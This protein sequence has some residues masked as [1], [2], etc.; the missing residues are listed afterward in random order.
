[1]K[2]VVYRYYSES[3]ELLYIGATTA[4]SERLICHNKNSSWFDAVRTI[5]IEHY[6]NYMDAFKAETKAIGAELP[7]HNVA[8]KP[9]DDPK[10]TSS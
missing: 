6:E 2:G 10:C 8:G 7:R 1:M 9:K 5:T 4:F 3:G